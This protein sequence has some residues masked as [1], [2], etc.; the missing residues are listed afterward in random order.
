MT[1]VKMIGGDQEKTD[2]LRRTILE[3]KFGLRLSNGGEAD[4]HKQVR[5][6]L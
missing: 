5:R 2:A 4:K 3:E 6:W 1:L